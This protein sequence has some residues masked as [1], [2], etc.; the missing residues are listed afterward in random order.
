MDKSTIVKGEPLQ[1]LGRKIGDYAKKYNLILDP[2]LRGIV[3]SLIN[4]SDL[5]IW[6]ELNPFEHLPR[7]AARKHLNLL[8]ITKVVT[9][10]RNVSVF[11]PVAVIWQAVGQA[12]TQFEIY[13]T[14]NSGAITNFLTFWQNGYGYLEYRYTIGHVAF[15]DFLIILGIIAL[16]FILNISGAI[17]ESM[18]D[19][20][21][22]V[23]DRERDQLCLDIFSELA[24]YRKANPE[25][26][27]YVL[28]RAISQINES[29]LALKKVITTSSVSFGDLQAITESAQAQQSNWAAL[30]LPDFKDFNSSLNRVVVALDK[31]SELSAVKIPSTL[32]G[33]LS[34]I[35]NITRN[36]KSADSSISKNT[37]ELMQEI[38]RLKTRLSRIKK[39]GK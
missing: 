4:Q 16:T 35:E 33:S 18:K 15:V 19:A 37:K 30:E 39:S 20:E 24:P 13:V 27:D 14:E 10:I 5:H 2:Y 9:I 25:A 26:L 8:N 12:T 11:I 32:Q 21:E 34:E 28:S 31:I 22:A 17:S 23:L 3:K 1:S 36:L 6:A 29:I 38:S 7:A